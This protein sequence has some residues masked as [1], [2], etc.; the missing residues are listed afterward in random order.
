M[1]NQSFLGNRFKRRSKMNEEGPCIC[2]YTYAYMYMHSYSV[3][4][5]YNKYTNQDLLCKLFKKAK[6]KDMPS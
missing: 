4:V 2:M 5:E 6:S 1:G 3:R